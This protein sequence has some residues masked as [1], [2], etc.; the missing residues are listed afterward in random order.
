MDKRIILLIAIAWL[1][2]LSFFVFHKFYAKAPGIQFEIRPNTDNTILHTGDSIAFQDN[3]VG[4]NRW[5]WDFG[6]GEYSSDKSGTHTYMNAGTFT[7]NLTAYGSYGS[8]KST[9]TVKVIQGNPVLSPTAMAILGPSEGNVKDQLSF[10]ASTNA[11]SYE[12]SVQ[13]DATQKVVKAQTATYSFAKPGAI[14]L[15]LKTKGPDATVSKSILVN[16]IVPAAAPAPVAAPVRH[17]SAP[18]PKPKPAE[19]KASKPKSN[20]LPDLGDGVEYHK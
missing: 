8:L 9:K 15:V 13:G 16:G 10:S 6:D 4:A 20:G 19:H 12:W 3:T 5:K 1:G 17:T 14:T 2:S 18:A 11:A 7:L